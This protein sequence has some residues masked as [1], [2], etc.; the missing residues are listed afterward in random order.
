MIDMVIWK[1]ALLANMPLITAGLLMKTIQYSEFVDTF[2]C[3]EITISR[4][5]ESLIQFDGESRR[6]GK[7][8]HIS[9]IPKAVKVLVPDEFNLVTYAKNIAPRLMEHLSALENIS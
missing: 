5:N 7:E 6:M 8:L 3:K 4:Q 9:V 1:R 2:R